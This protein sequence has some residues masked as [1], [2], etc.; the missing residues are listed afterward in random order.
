MDY[1]EKY[2]PTMLLNHLDGLATEKIIGLE[3]DYDR[4][5]TAL[6]RHYNNHAKIIATCV[7]E[8]KALP[9]IIPR[10]YKAL[11]SYKRC[12]VNNNTRLSTVGLEHEVS[13]LDTMKQL[14]SKLPWVQVE[15]WN[16]FIEEQ[17]DETK[18]KPFE[19]FLKWL[20]KAG[21]LWEIVV[22]LGVGCA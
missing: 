8:V 14:V 1:K 13:N 4:A 22:A 7:K 21:R 18:G 10:D 11:V 5:M 19:T 15:K 9:K 6:D 20:E 12:I 2:R 3:N 17:E 16:E